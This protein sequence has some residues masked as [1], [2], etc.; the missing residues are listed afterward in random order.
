MLKW[1]SPIPATHSD[2]LSRKAELSP[3]KKKSVNFI[4]LVTELQVD[5]DLY[6]IIILWFLILSQA[7]LQLQVLPLETSK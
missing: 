1:V 3:F 7:S 6:Q 5:L 4:S 2:L